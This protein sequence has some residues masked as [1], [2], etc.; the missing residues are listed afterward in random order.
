MLTATGSRGRQSERALLERELDAAA[1]GPA[2]LA[3]E[4]GPGIGKTTLVREAIAGA[5]TRGY[6]VIATAPAEPDSS[7]A[8][9]GIADLLDGLPAEIVSALPAPQRRAVEAALVLTDPVAAPADPQALPRALVRIFRRLAAETPLLIAIDDEQWLDGASARALAFGLCRLRE[10]PVCVVLARRSDGDSVLW[11]ELARGYGTGGLPAMSL[12]PLSM[13]DIHELLADRLGLMLSPTLLREI[14]RASAGNPLYA[15]AIG[16]ELL[17]T[18]AA[19]AEHETL[20]IPATLSEAIGR[21]LAALPA[22]SMDALFVIAALRRPTIALIQAVLPDFTLTDLDE[23]VEAGVVEMADGTVRF[24]HPLLASTQY[25]RV[26]TARR[27]RLH[28]L[29]A[30]IAGDDIE[31]AHHLALGAEAPDRELA[32]TLEQAARD[33]VRR[34]APETAA[35]LL[36]HACRL[37]PADAAEARASRTVAA[38]EHH[39]AAGDLV[40]AR[41][42]L[43]ALLRDLPDG[44]IRARALLSL[45]RVRMDDFQAAAGLLEEALTQTGDHHRIAAQA[46]SLLSELAANMGDRASASA[47]AGTAVELAGRSGDRGLLA[48][49]LSAMS[50]MAFFAGEGVQ[51]QLLARAIE[52][53]PDA[54]GTRSYLMPTTTL[55]LQRFWSDELDRA[56]PLLERSL[57]RAAERGEEYDRVGL[58]FHLAHL[59]TE[60][61]R[62]EVADRYTAE[63]LEL[64]RQIADDQADCYASWLQAYRA[65]RRGDLDVATGHAGQAIEVAT[66]IGDHFIATFS[67]VILAGAEL[68]DGRPEAAHARLPGLRLGL[69]ADGNGFIGSLTLG[70]WTYDIEALIALGRGDEAAELTAELDGRA[71]DSGNPNAVAIA[72]RCRALLLADR[73]DPAA[74][75]R[76]LD[77]GLADHALRPLPLEVG[78][79]LLEKGTIERRAK[80][81][82]AA[83]RSLEDAVAVLEPLGAAMWVARARDELGRVGLRRARPSVGLTPAEQRVA[84][85]VA[86]GMSNREVASALYMSLRTVEAHLTR[87]YRELGIRSRGQLVAALAGRAGNQ[88]IGDAGD[89]ALLAGAGDSRPDR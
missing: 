54:A 64:G 38:A 3:L 75:V 63:C 48:Q 85:L 49:T 50:L 13:S 2:G 42:I 26:A 44:P 72:R 14:Y 40:R 89:G 68:W 56:R 81:K 76:E 17:A 23:A 62:P 51:D 1:G 24:T 10:E 60:A 57:V 34:G 80:R 79:T 74:A 29:L 5:R 18:P 20:P 16:R 22:C 58:L 78:R 4:G 33:A 25:E 15:L 88:T 67:E 65:A 83:K 39:L 30:D 77:A 27:R 86:G 87:I 59:E 82:S 7:L 21:R 47:H 37:T 84:E 53:E 45:A 32:M 61:G 41:T 66:R 70:L 11:P 19:P 35:Q 69:V 9:A 31:R 12:A 52:L 55:G 43:E 8:F 46:E 6:G 36:A 73:G 71:Q 28:R